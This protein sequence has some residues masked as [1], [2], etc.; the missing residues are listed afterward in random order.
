MDE[1]EKPQS[2][3]KTEEPANVTRLPRRPRLVVDR[4]LKR[5]PK[6]G[7]DYDTKD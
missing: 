5:R 1:K 7:L 4:Q 3:T 2:K 6:T